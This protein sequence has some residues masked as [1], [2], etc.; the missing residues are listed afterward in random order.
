MNNNQMNM[1]YQNNNQMY[2]QNN[3]N[4]KLP[5]W[6]IVL[7]ILAACGPV[8]IFVLVIFGSVFFSFKTINTNKVN[9]EPRYIE[10]YASFLQ[11][12]YFSDE[13]IYGEVNWV[14][15]Y[16]GEINFNLAPYDYTYDIDCDEGYFDEYGDITLYECTYEDSDKEY[17]YI[18]GE[19]VESYR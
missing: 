1:N 19:A 5:T 16:T 17:D 12:E 18:D 3:N 9:M 7:I 10:N 4:S 2:N 13:A 14:N 6:A 11:T 8:L 15:E